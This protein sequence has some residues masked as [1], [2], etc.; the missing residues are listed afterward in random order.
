M[1]AY[2]D[3]DDW[4]SEVE[5]YSLRAERFDDDARTGDPAVIRKWLETAWRLGGESQQAM[6]AQANENWLRA[7]KQALAGDTH[8]LQC[9]I[10]AAEGRI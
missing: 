7:A 10:D 3:L 4:L 9:W 2:L 1:K 8:Q 6:K 5:A